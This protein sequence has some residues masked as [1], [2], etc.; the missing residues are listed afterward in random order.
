MS[1]SQSA[2]ELT[3][4][5]THGV[6][7]ISV[8]RVATEILLFVSMVVLAHLIPPAA[9][10]Q[11]AIAVIV[12]ELAMS[13]PTEGVGSA[14][15][16]R[17]TVDKEHLQAG[18][19]MAIASGIVL[20]GL[21]LVLCTF[22]IG[23]IFGAQTA[24]LSR[25][26][27]VMFP[28]AAT[29]AA[30]IA[31][32]RRRLDFRALSIMEISA[33]V[34]RA[35]VS[36]GLAAVIGLQGSALVWG[37][38]AATTAATLV[39][40]AHARPP[41]PWPRPRAARDIAE[42]GGFASLASFAWI[43]FRNGDYAVVAARLGSTAAGIYWRAFQ[44]AVEYQRKIS[45]VM[46]SVAFPILARSTDPDEMF[47][48]RRRMVRLMT[49]VTF[50][51]L[52]GLSATAPVIIPFV[53]GHNWDSAV[54]PTQILCGAGA[55]TLVIDAV[56]TTLM[57]SGRPR[58]L[59]GY[60]VAHFVTYVG[61]VVLVSPLGLPWV[62]CAAVTVHTVFLL[63][64]Y[65]LLVPKQPV[66][67]ARCLWDD[68]GPATA[69]SLFLVAAAVGIAILASEVHMA[70][71]AHVALLMVVCPPAYLLSLRTLFR[72]SWNDLM[73]LAQRMLPAPLASASLS[74]RRW[75]QQPMPAGSR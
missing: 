56:G 18:Q 8:S 17:K 36:V 57:A 25:L 23:P 12:Q 47:A 64:A 21:T 63:I 75:R 74:L 4:A 44:L 58:A 5:A 49:V 73:T 61:T 42:Y 72:D 55:A 71:A 19:F 24:D 62:A 6:R 38:L 50:P 68:A 3:R 37:A 45:I 32:L 70:G 2:A 22:V 34:T 67:A 11:F 20:A 1:E 33:S 46:Y 10:G 40:F 27:A 29:G 48:L 69:A 43:G 28:L 26:S 14:L 13:L 35:V 39:A 52:A 66:R 30:P 51:L 53:F 54:V 31:V 59:F 7:W 15:V 60:G 41:V 9:F 65:L 16:Q